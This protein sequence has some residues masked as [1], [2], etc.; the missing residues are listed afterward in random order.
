MTTSNAFLDACFDFRAREAYF[1]YFNIGGIDKGIYNRMMDSV[2][3]VM[4]KYA[5]EVEEN[6]RKTYGQ[7]EP[8]VQTAEKGESD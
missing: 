1:N 6:L 4:L 8:L 7:D 5:A 3:D 2:K